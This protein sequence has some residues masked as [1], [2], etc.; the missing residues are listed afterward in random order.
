VRATRK[1]RICSVS[2]GC[3]QR[4]RK[5]VKEAL[6][7]TTDQIIEIKGGGEINLLKFFRG[8]I[9]FFYD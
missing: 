6:M 1:R 2:L 4:L 8:S 7:P 5:P 3:S 9:G